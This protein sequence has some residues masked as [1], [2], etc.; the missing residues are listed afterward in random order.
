MNTEQNINNAE[1]QAVNVDPLVMQDVL[2]SMRAVVDD[3]PIL[4]SGSFAMKLLWEIYEAAADYLEKFEE[5]MALN[6]DEVE[7]IFKSAFPIFIKNYP[8][9]MFLDE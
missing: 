6:D 9:V 2:A 4:N 7:H 3:H 1:G 5:V 8:R